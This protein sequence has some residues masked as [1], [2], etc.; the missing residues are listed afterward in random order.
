MTANPNAIPEGYAAITPYLVIQ[1][2]AEAIE[3]YKTVFHAQERMCMKM[4]DGKV[5]HAELLIENSVIMLADE[6]TGWRSP[7]AIG[8][9]PVALHL[10]V[11]NVDLVID[12]ALAHG[13]MLQ[14]AVENQFYGDRSGTVVDPFG[15][16]WHVAT[17]VEDVSPEEIA[18]R[19]KTAIPA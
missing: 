3:Y 15:H 12:R 1:G 8:G 9:S 18:R 16:I 11:E 2:A 10:Y 17:H 13:A 14:R 7:Q 4:P 19:A 6:C 5:A